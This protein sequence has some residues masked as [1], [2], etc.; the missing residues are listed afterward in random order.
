MPE[1]SQAESLCRPWVSPPGGSSG[2]GLPSHEPEV[3][4]I[5][6][7]ETPLGIDS[8]RGAD[9]TGRRGAFDQAR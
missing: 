5:L 6:P 1:R 9:S 4:A 7:R 2:E 3:F 8:R